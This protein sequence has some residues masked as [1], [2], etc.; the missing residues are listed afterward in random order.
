[1]TAKIRIGKLTSTT[2]PRCSFELRVEIRLPDGG[3][4][5]LT[6]EMTPEEFANV[7]TGGME[8]LPIDDETYPRRT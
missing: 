2:D 7:A 4:R 1:M 6:A 5:V 8:E 3:R